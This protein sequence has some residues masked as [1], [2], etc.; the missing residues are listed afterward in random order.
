LEKKNRGFF[1]TFEGIE[2]SGKSTQ[3]DLLTRHLQEKGYDVVSTRDPGGTEL[4]DSIRDVLLN[5]AFSSMDSYTELF[6]YAASRAQLI[7]EIIEPALKAGKIVLCDRF[8]DST[9]AY[10]G[11][12]RGIS[13][14]KIET[15]NR[16]AAKEIFPQLTI[17]LTIPAQDGLDRATRDSID[18][19]EEESISF[20]QRV[21]SGYKKLAQEQPGRICIIDASGDRNEIQQQVAQIVEDILK[22]GR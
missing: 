19:I 6:L 3:I 15:L 22:K 1:I 11:F 13:F 4:G 5:P 10:Q 17:I 20:H 18:R 9:I 12:G 7:K 8:T 16:W 14:D 2:G 21:E